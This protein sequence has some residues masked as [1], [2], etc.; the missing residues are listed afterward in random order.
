[1]NCCEFGKCTQGFGCPV[2]MTT[3]SDTG[4]KVAHGKIVNY[5][6]KA[7]QCQP[8]LPVVMFDEPYYIRWMDAALSWCERNRFWIACVLTGAALGFGWGFAS[9]LKLF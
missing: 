8:E 2:R 7:A 5:F 1:M 9:L 4:H 3:A 6:G